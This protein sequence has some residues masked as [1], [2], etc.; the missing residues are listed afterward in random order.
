MA[1]YWEEKVIHFNLCCA[2]NHRFD[3]WFRS[4]EDFEKQRESGLIACPICGATKVEKALMTPA[5]VN[6]AN[7]DKEDKVPSLTQGEER[8]LWQQWRQF[9]RQIRENAD[10]VGKDF[11]EQ[12]RKIH[13]GEVKPRPI[14]GEAQRTEI[15]SLLEDGIEV[16]P[17]PPLPEK[18]N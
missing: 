9:A 2:H 14:Y 8:A 3:G 13:F 5:L 15:V 10:Y 17:L 1:C 7:Q 11:A 12:A 16:V 4:N 18:Q 6:Q